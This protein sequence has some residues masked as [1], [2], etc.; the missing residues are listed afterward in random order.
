MEQHPAVY[1]QY[2][3]H[4]TANVVSTVPT[5]QSIID[6]RLMYAA[7][8]PV[9]E[10]YN[11]VAEAERI[12]REAAVVAEAEQITRTAAAQQGITQAYGGNI[13][14]QYQDGT[15]SYY[16]PV[17]ASMTSPSVPA[18][19]AFANQVYDETVA[20]AQAQAFGH[21]AANPELD[22]AL[23]RQEID[24]LHNADGARV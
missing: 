21:P 12:A 7:H 20:L 18:E 2:A 14:S 4:L 3:G 17:E 11:P 1:P 8:D 10:N 22:P 23:I 24:I 19:V 13:P 16:A 5:E 9:N 15:P 6:R